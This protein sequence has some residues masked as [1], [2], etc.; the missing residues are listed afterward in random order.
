[1]ACNCGWISRYALAIYVAY[2]IGVEF[3]RRI[4]GEVMPQL[5]RLIQPLAHLD[6]VTL[7]SAVYIVGVF[8]VL[9]YFFFSKEQGMVTKPIEGGQ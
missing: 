2:Y 4:H 6:S 9:T 3:T 5:A 7:V 8:S 1:M